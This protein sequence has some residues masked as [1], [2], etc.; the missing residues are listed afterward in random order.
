MLRASLAL[1]RGRVAE[2]ERGWT[3][4]DAG[5]GGE[6]VGAHAVAQGG[7]ENRLLLCSGG[8]L[9]QDVQSGGH[10]VNPGVGEVLGEGVEQHGAPCPARSA[11]RPTAFRR[12]VAGLRPQVPQRSGLSG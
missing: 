7:G 9:E 2:H 5:M 10:A 8:Q 1:R 12:G 6:R 3:A 4:V 11:W